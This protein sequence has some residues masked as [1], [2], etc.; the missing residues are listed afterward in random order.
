VDDGVS[1]PDAGSD[2]ALDAPDARVDPAAFHGIAAAT[3]A[4][5]V[6]LFLLLAG[7]GL[8][9]SLLGVRA[10]LEGFPT[11]ASGIIGASYYAGFLL[12]SRGAFEALGRVGHVRVYSALASMASIAILAQGFAPIPWVWAALRLLTGFCMAGQYVVAESWLNDLATNET[13]GRLLA[14]YMVV[15]SAGFGAGQLLLGTADVAGF[16]LFAVAAI[17]TSLA[18]VPVALSE[19]ATAPSF[20]SLV[21][22]SLRDLARI[23]PTGVG[24]SLLVGVAHG[25]MLGMAA[26]Y[27]SSAG[28]SPGQVAVFVF[29]P[30]LG[31]VVLQWP[32]SAAS[33]D[34]D[35][36]AVTIAAACGSMVAVGLLLLVEPGSSVSFLLVFLLGGTSYPLYS[37]A[38]AYTNDW[39][40]PDQLAGAATQ[41]VTLYGAGAFIG[42]LVAAAWMGLSGPHAYYWTVLALHGLIVVFVTY[43]MFAWRAPIVNRPWNEVSIPARAFFVPATV[44][45]LVLRHRRR[46]RAA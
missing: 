17:L 30:M 23:V 2:G 39:T 45:S 10:E 11:M 21:P 6:G 46:R 32:I 27:A 33:D 26:V 28:L 24:T 44:I 4:L 3:W 36:R 19:A 13:R 43:R 7:S 16:T 38:A 22:I 37:L 14:V 40:P 20:R 8:V 15:T 1:T 18:T 12:G 35:R 42:P 34:V 29:M 9:G 5:F 31:G 41:L 25:A